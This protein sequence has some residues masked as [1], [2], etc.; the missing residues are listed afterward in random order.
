MNT[1]IVEYEGNQLE[2]DFDLDRPQLS[3]CPKCASDII[4]LADGCRICGWS[5]NQSLSVV[6]SSVSIPCTV[7]QPNQPERSGVIKQDLGSRFLVYIPDADST[8]TVPKLFVYPD[9]KQLDKCSSKNIPSSKKCSSKN[10]IPASK[11]PPSKI[12]RQ[13]GEGSGAIFYRTITKNGKEYQQAYY[14]WRENGKQRSKY[15]PNKLLDKVKQAESR[16]LPVSDILVLLPGTSK[17]SSKKFDTSIISTDAKVIDTEDKCSSK[18]IPGSKRRRDQGKGSGWIKCKP[19]KRKGKEYK[20]YWY[21]YEEWREGDRM[22]QSSKYIPKKMETKI[23]R[24]NNEKVSVE[25]IL[26]V[27]QNRIKRK[28]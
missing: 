4:R 9:L 5:E 21:Y 25:K 2:I 27:L 16:K 18:T 17:C 15:I 22:I 20:Q 26:K 24:M 7:K 1:P 3:L 8:V 13:K 10:S 14:H 12:R 28:R 19:I 11:I 23:I 6:E